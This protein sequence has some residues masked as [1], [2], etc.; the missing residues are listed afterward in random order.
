MPG[1]TLSRRPALDDKALLPAPGNLASRRSGGSS[2]AR[3]GR[4]RSRDACPA[5]LRGA[6]RKAFLLQYRASTTKGRP[7]L[8]FGQWLGL[9]RRLISS[10][11]SRGR[12]PASKP[13]SL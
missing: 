5:L 11:S 3:G 13:A 8:S 2:A 4:G 10:L 7:A 6:W 12:P 1:P 9:R